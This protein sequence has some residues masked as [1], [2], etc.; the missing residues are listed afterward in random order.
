MNDVGGTDW[1]LS[2]LSSCSSVDLPGK[3]IGVTL[4]DV[5]RDNSDLVVSMKSPS[6]QQSES[7]DS[8]K[9]RNTAET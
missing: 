5:R 2:D 9:N 7:C 3:L 6:S 1:P 4:A 8:N